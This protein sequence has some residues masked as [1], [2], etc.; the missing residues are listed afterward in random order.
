MKSKSNF[1]FFEFH[2]SYKDLNYDISKLNK[3]KS[4][5][6]HAPELFEGDH[7]LDLS[8]K[9]DEY[10]KKSIENLQRV[11]DLTNNLIDINNIKTSVGIIT[12]VG[13]FSKSNFI[14][15]SEKPEMYR[16][17]IDAIRLLK[18]TDK[19]EIWPQTMPPYPW[20][21]GGQSYHNLF[22]NPDEI[23]EFCSEFNIKI[24]TDVSHTALYCFTEKI[25]LFE[26]LNKILPYTSHLHIA[27]SKSP[28]GEGLQ[29]GEGNIDWD[30]FCKLYKNN[31]PKISF[32][33]E[34]WQ[35]H[36]DDG[37]GFWYAL[38]KLNL[39]LK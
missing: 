9:N 10:R 14:N 37:A 23:V 21:F 32:I 22:A 11:V 29:I 4:F 35:G 30:T 34:I 1:D 28:D 5:V 2:L 36:N 33:P 8:S 19:I 15:K 12:N 26:S 7:L 16:R 3:V 17:V 27:D 6:I 39:K 25:D 20:H 24:C 31:Y 13:G 18:N 38:N